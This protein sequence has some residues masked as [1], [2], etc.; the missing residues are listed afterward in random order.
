MEFFGESKKNDLFAGGAGVF[1]L[2]RVAKL[3]KTV[4][5]K[6]PGQENEDC[7]NESGDYW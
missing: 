2:V 5:E 4:A 1:P 6:S 7:K 3:V